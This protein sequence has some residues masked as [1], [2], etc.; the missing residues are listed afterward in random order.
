MALSHISFNVTS[1]KITVS[2]ALVP[3]GHEAHP[4]FSFQLLTLGHKVLRA[5]VSDSFV[6]GLIP[7]MIPSTDRSAHNTV[8]AS[9]YLLDK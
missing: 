4:L 9:Q 1:A 3:R 7:N 5:P 8:G 2:V 6:S